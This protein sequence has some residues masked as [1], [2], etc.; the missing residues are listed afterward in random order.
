VTLQLSRSKPEAL[1]RA[2]ETAL[3]TGASD[4]TATPARVVRNFYR[5]AGVTTHG[6][7]RGAHGPCLKGGAMDDPQRDALWRDVRQQNTRLQK[8]IDAITQLVARS[9]E[10]LRRQRPEDGAPAG[11]GKNEGRD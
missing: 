10:V 6:P 7:A 4:C 5:R 3:R 9:R 11:F 2:Y 8:L 1:D